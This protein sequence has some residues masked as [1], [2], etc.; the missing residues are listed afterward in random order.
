MLS[1]NVPSELE[2]EPWPERVERG[3]IE[4]MEW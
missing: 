1:G 4:E 3:G 2:D